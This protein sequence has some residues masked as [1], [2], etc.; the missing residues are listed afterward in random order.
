MID[1]DY[2][3]I[4][5]SIIDNGCGIDKKDI[6]HVFKPLFSTKASQKNYGLGLS[7]TKN[8]IQKNNGYIKIKSKP[9]IGT[10]V[11][12]ILPKYNKRRFDL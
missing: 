4:S 11:Q 6:K 10:T 2:D 5:V 1:Y 7:Y 12:V 9:N 8:I 3:L